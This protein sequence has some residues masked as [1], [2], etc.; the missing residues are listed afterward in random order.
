MLYKLVIL[1][2]FIQSYV[3]KI[4][5]A[6]TGN[7]HITPIMMRLLLAPESSLVFSCILVRLPSAPPRSIRLSPTLAAESATQIP[8]DAA[9]APLV[10]PLGSFAMDVVLTTTFLEPDVFL[11]FVHQILTGKI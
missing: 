5:S 10:H 8:S 11:P 1:S 3:I 7:L 2:I 6:P 9:R 4:S